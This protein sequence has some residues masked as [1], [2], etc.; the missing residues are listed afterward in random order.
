MKKLN[1]EQ[2]LEFIRNAIATDGYEV[3]DAANKIALE[4]GAITTAQYIDAAHLVVNAFLAQ[5]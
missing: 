1:T 2:Y 4:K 3:A 5:N